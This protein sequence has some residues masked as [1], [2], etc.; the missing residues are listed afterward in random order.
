MK[1]SPRF[2]RVVEAARSGVREIETD[3]VHARIQHGDPFHLIDVREESE[4]EAGH[5]PSA[6]HIGR[7]VLER[8]IEKLVPDAD[9]DIVL[10]CGGGFRSVLAAESLQKMGYTNVRSMT[11]GFRGWETSSL[12]I[13]R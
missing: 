2:L 12:P 8:D 6:T 3:T 9:A 7:G 11:G 5:L 13:T 10:Y 1:H 4:W